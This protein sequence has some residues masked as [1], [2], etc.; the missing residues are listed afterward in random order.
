MNSSTKTAWA[1]FLATHY[2]D[3]R[4][5]IITRG[6]YAVATGSANAYILALDAQIVAYTTWDSY[7]FKANFTNSASCTLNINSLGAKTLKDQEWNVLWSGAIANWA[8]I[9]ATYNGT[10]II[11]NSWLVSTT[12]N[13][14]AIEIATDAE[15]E[16]GTDEIRSV[17]P[18]QV[19]IVK[20]WT[21]WI[22][23][24]QAWPSSATITTS[25]SILINTMTIWA[26]TL[27]VTSTWADAH[28]SK[29]QT[30]PDD[31]TWTD[32]YIITGASTR[33]FS[34]MM[35]QWLYYR[36]RTQTVSSGGSEVST[37]S[38]TYTI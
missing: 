38:L 12:S 14:W 11:I 6:D 5:D 4:K 33:N 37:A 3:L 35:K 20:N 10:D 31:S 9:Y 30:S 15:Y 27:S 24:S 32:L 36:T 8:L 29:I 13:K 1:D 25:T 16:T 34:F 2:N 28:T 7:I 22:K 19:K 26:V 21:Y 23:T 18:K 17:N